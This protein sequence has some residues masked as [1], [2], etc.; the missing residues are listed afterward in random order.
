MIFRG[1]VYLYIC[2]VHCTN[3]LL[4]VCTLPP[5]PK[6]TKALPMPPPQGPSPPSPLLHRPPQRL[7]TGGHLP[8][9]SCHLPLSPHNSLVPQTVICPCLPITPL[10]PV[11]ICCRLLLSPRLPATLRQEEMIYYCYPCLTEKYVTNIFFIF[12]TKN[13]GF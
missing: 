1:S 10:P 11:E 8:K 3:P 13:K 9:Q 7:H 12:E 6:L 2:T 4:V 5:Q